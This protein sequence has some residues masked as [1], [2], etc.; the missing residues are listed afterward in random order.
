MKRSA[1]G[2]IAQGAGIQRPLLTGTVAS[3]SGPPTVGECGAPWLGGGPTKLFLQNLGSELNQRTLK[4]E[5]GKYVEREKY[6]LQVS[7]E[8]P[9]AAG[10]RR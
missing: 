10:P 1:D 8:R 7:P 6:V 4:E 5:F 2:R 9:R 3:Y